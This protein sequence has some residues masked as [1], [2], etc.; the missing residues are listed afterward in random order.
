MMA[1]IPGA[2]AVGR[3]FHSNGP[4]ANSGAAGAAGDVVQA[5]A[6]VDSR[7]EK[8]RTASAPNSD[9][10]ARVKAYQEFM[11]AKGQL[12]ALQGAPVPAQQ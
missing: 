11:D 9:P 3:L 4:A 2:G 12:Q 1:S 5:K 6:L 8:F 10:T 7:Y